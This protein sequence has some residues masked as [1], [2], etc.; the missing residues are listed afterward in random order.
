MNANIT[1]T[2]RKTYKIDGMSCRSCENTVNR[3]AAAAAGV[4]RAK[5]DYV[6][7]TLSLDY[8]PADFT[9]EKLFESVSRKGYGIQ[10]FDKVRYFKKEILPVLIGG[11]LIS[12][13]G[14]MNRIPEIREKAG[15]PVIF[16][17]G[18]FTSLHCIGMCGGI[19]LSQTLDTS[20]AQMRRE[21]FRRGLLYNGGRVI[22]YTLIGGI[23]GGIGS[24]LSVSLTLQGT[25][26]IVAGLI[27][28]IMGLNMLGLRSLFPFGIPH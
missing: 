19:N 11:L 22:S 8:F 10:D 17:I 5:S 9:R 13:T 25:I 23:V 16:L 7:G 12:K 6:K 4:Y 28:L 14:I 2:V 1:R 18:L 24:T 3:A 15:L 27:M 21:T 26:I 20:A